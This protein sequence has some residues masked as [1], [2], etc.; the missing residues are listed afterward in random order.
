[1]AG[2]L[3]F[4]GRIGPMNLHLYRTFRILSTLVLVAVLGAACAPA[5]TPTPTIDVQAAV[6]Q[7]MAT[8]LAQA[9]QAAQSVPTA[10]N[11]PDPTATVVRT[12]PAL[13]TSFTTDLLNPRDTPHT[14]I[15][16][17][18]QYLKAK[19][20]P[21]NAAPGTVVLVIMFHGIAKGVA[22]DN[23]SISMQDFHK[24]MNDLHDMGFE[25]IDTQQLADFL[26][27]NAKIPP[28]SVLLTV[29][30]RHQAQSFTDTF[31][32]FYNQWGWKVVNGWISA[33][34]GNDPYL[35]ENVDLSKAGWVDYQAHGVVHNIPISS[36]SSDDFIHNELYGS[37]QNIKQYF[38]KT[39]IAYIWPGG[40]FT[41]K[42]AQVA[43]QAGY[44][45]GFTIN[46]R[47]PVMYNWVPL[48]DASDPQ[49]PSYLADGPVD[50]PLMVLPRYWDTD[51]RDHL[52]DVR[53]I[54]K[55][56]AAYAQQ[57]KATELDYYNIVCAPTDGPIPGQ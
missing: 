56:A 29:D 37:I 17:A 28:R 3:S 31:L 9:T 33:F 45:L 52:D 4:W 24:L 30:D 22:T 1:M 51:A 11:P 8:A 39:P 35:Q 41:P 57:N 48:D 25:A 55:A 40:G 46:P 19:W 13:P 43:R 50:D 7:A 26:Y 53:N 49:R 34:G 47:G 15:Q 38:G 21:N 6:T 23:K 14:Y 20:D 44:K 42:A 5:A 54:G 10:T 16:D 32:P 2:V 36:G 12:P 27:N 18:C